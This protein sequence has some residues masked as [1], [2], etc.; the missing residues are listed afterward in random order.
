MIRIHRS[1]DHGLEAIERPSKGCWIGVIDP[2]RDEVGSLSRD[3]HVPVE[4]VRYSLDLDKI[5]FVERTDDALLI[6]V[7][8]GHLESPTANI[9]YETLPLG[10]ILTDDRVV[11]ISRHENGLLRDP[12]HDH[13]ADLSTANSTRFVLHLLWSIA[14]N[15]LRHLSE[16]NRTV[17]QLEDRL[18]RSLQ[19]REVLKLLRY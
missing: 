19:N 3:L 15:Y 1:T 11:T 8:V 2:D 18:Q 13:Q 16:I 9:P 4:F 14:N 7:R 6:L 10:I 17:E 5:S 12:P